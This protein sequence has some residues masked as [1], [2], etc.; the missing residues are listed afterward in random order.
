MNHRFWKVAILLHSNHEV[1][2]IS[3]NVRKKLKIVTF[4][5][6]AIFDVIINFSLISEYLGNVS[7]MRSMQGLII[8][9]CDPYPGGGTWAKQV[10]GMCEP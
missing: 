6:V 9:A 5:D 3:G 1:Y 4:L 10:T 8:T 7:V 2:I